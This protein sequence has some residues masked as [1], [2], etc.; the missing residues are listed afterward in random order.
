MPTDASSAPSK[1]ASG[2]SGLSFDL[3]MPPSDSAQSSVRR[4]AG[5]VDA[6]NKY[7]SQTERLLNPPHPSIGNKDWKSAI[8]PYSPA[9]EGQNHPPSLEKLMPVHASQKPVPT[10]LAK[11]T[12]KPQ[13]QP[14]ASADAD[15]VRRS[16]Q[17]E[18]EKRQKMLEHLKQSH[19][20]ELSKVNL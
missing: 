12:P 20:K 19:A 5:Y 17:L 2:D 4:N 3:S 9:K 15:Y 13:Q 1:V 18:L 6:K 16:H 10:E 14:G 11:P 7:K 8:E